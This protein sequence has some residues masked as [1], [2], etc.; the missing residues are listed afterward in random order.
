MEFQ[1]ILNDANCI[2]APF[3]KWNLQPS[4]YRL[5]DKNV[6]MVN[7]QAI[8]K[9]YNFN[10]TSLACVRNFATSN[11]DFYKK[12]TKSIVKRFGM[13]SHRIN[14][15]QR[16]QVSTGIVVCW[17]PFVICNCFI[18]QLSTIFILYT[19]Q[20]FLATQTHQRP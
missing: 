9:C 8:Q 5:L 12:L 20:I 14:C 16:N 13:V 11:E 4:L 2:F 3:L 17:P 1:I 7:C 15:V 18:L 6:T 10:W 19:E